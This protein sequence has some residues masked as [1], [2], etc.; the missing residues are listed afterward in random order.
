MSRELSAEETDAV[1][2]SR[3]IRLKEGMHAV[4]TVVLERATAALV[5]CAVSGECAD[6]D[7]HAGELRL[8]TDELR[9]RRDG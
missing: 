4:P 3:H 7:H 9:R 5:S 2:T 6:D 1:H 8:L